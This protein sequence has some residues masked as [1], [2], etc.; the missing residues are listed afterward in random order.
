MSSIRCMPPTISAT[1]AVG[2]D[3]E[4]AIESR[5]RVQLFGGHLRQRHRVQLA[6]HVHTSHRRDTHTG[7]FGIDDVHAVARDD[8]DRVRHAGIG[9]EQ[10]LA[11]EPA[12]R[13]RSA[14]APRDPSSD[15]GST[16]ASVARASPCAIG[17][18]NW[19]FCARLA[20]ASS[21]APAIATVAK[22][23][24]GSSARPAS[25]ISSTSSTTPRPTPPCASSKMMP[26]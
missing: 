6:R 4:R 24:P 8:H 17:A 20:H 14:G 16:N 25:S 7:R 1:S 22:S 11:R 26:V 12:V 21:T 3:V 9:H 2:R 23:G 5:E 19:C 18:R 10:L 13:S 15:V